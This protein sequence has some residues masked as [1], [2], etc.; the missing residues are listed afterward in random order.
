[1]ST[2]R[3]LIQVLVVLWGSGVPGSYLA[4]SQAAAGSFVGLATGGSS[5]NVR[6]HAVKADGSYCAL[7]VSG[8][9]EWVQGPG[10]PGDHNSP[11]VGIAA[12]DNGC[13]VYAM[14]AN[15]QTYSLIFG[16]GRAVDDW[17][18]R[19]L[20]TAGDGLVA[21]DSS[22]WTDLKKSYKD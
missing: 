3:L 4:H 5:C 8:V 21:V 11:V 19:T 1:M 20:L 14:R 18:W 22:T 13:G 9:E 2:K 17:Y 16:G 10:V 7:K 15:R 12:T 6:I